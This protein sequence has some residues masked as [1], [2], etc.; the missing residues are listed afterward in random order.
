MRQMLLNESSFLT[1]MPPEKIDD[2]TLGKSLAKILSSYLL[3]VEGIGWHVWDGKRWTSKGGQIYADGLVQEVVQKWQS[4]LYSEAA[5]ST[6]EG[7][8]KETL[9]LLETRIKALKG[10]S[11]IYKR[12]AILESAKPHGLAVQP[13]IMDAQ[14]SMINL[15]NGTFNLYT[16]K[17]QPH[18]QSDYIT[19][20]AGASYDT[21]AQYPR[22]QQFIDE[23]S[24]GDS[25]ISAYHQRTLGYALTGERDADCMLVHFGEKTRN[26][27]STLAEALRAALGDYA[28]VSAPE[29]FALQRNRS[30][31]SPSE[32]R[33]RIR[34]AR[35]VFVPEPSK[36]MELDAA[37]VKTLTGGDPIPARNLH[38]SSIEFVPQ[39]LIVMHTNYLPRIDDQTLFKSDR[40]ICIPFNREF[41]GKTQDQHLSR[42]L[43]SSN[44]RNTI[45]LWLLAGYMQYKKIGIKQNQPEAVRGEISKYADAS[46]IFGIFVD[47]NIEKAEGSFL[48]AR[49]AYGKYTYWADENGYRAMSEVNFAR[50]MSAH[51][52]EKHRTKS[53]RGYS[54]IQLTGWT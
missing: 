42:K 2:I 26:G 36:G 48:Q 52:F 12:K 19:K 25:S 38:Q 22:W 32:D 1:C 43:T 49:S 10:Y 34:G 13:D 3:Y 31:G 33:M 16:G 39:C 54:D 47:E 46:D 35:L 7:A 37:L 51:G 18:K 11:A 50:E 8:A 21:N 5:N 15:Q 17:L 44:A 30:S 27:K 28:I 6:S 4:N 14:L 29:T 41:T 24:N 45:L 9:Y 53:A 23:I 40:M 20:L